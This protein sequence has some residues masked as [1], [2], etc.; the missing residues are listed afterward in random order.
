[1]SMTR[2]Q[3]EAAGW[4]LLPCKVCKRW[5]QCTASRKDYI[6]IKISDNTSDVGFEMLL[7][8]VTAIESYP[9]AVEMLEEAAVLLVAYR[10]QCVNAD[11]L[12]DLGD[13]LLAKLEA[14][15]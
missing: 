6:V 13:S 11:D 5:H 10:R 3:A 8:A 9:S 2:E 14:M 12:K 15:P 1:M 7:A 4:T